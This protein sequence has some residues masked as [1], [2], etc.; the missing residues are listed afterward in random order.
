LAI[1]IKE[2]SSSVP[3]FNWRKS[4]QVN[5]VS[6]AAFTSVNGSTW[7]EQ[8]NQDFFYKV[9]YDINSSPTGKHRIYT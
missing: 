2:T 4:T 5:P 1:V 6:G 3:L 7:Y 9:H 8:L